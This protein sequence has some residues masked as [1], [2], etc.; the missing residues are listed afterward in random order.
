MQSEQFQLH[1]EIEQRHWWFVARRRIM[2][3]LV[4]ELLPSSPATTIVDVGCGTGGNIAC[5]A[6]R[7]G[8]AGIDTSSQA[9]ELAEQ[10]FPSVQFLVGRAPDDLGELMRRARLFLLMDVLEHVSDDFA[11][12]S[13]LFCAATPGSYFLLTVPADESLWSRHDESFAHYRRYDMERFV[14]LWADWPVATLMVSYFNSRLLPL[15]RLIR[16]RGRRRG[17][18]AGQAG[19]DFWVPISPIN[20]LLE[21]V[22]SGEARRLVNLLHG[23]RTAGYPSGAS[24]IA[25]VRRDEGIIPLRHKPSDLP[26][27]HAI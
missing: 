21:A 24:L 14:R 9:V 12:L 1:A 11:A 4:G 20:R 8:C 23:R 19:T 16:S 6:D 5:L 27:D 26:A 10:R 22:F 18:V 13:E 2:R 25:I 7:Y 17:R 3:R 15:I